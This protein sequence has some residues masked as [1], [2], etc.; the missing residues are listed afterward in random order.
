MA[1]RRFVSGLLAL[2]IIAIAPVQDAQSF[3]LGKEGA[4]FGRLG[5]PGKVSPSPI[6]S[7]GLVGWW[8]F[9]TATTSFS[10]NT[11][12]DL[13]TKRHNGTLANLSAP[14][15]LTFNGTT[16]QV[17]VAATADYALSSFSVSQWLNFSALGSWTTTFEHN[18][19]GLNWIFMGKSGNGNFGVWR[20]SQS[21][22]NDANTILAT[23]QDY[24]FTGTYDA[25]KAAA[26][27]YLNGLADVYFDATAPTPTSD[28]TSI[29]LNQSGAEGFT[30]TFPLK[31]GTK[32]YNRQ[33]T[34]TEAGALYKANSGV[35]PVDIVIDTDMTDIDD[36]GAIYLALA[37]E[38][39]GYVNIKA[40][41]T[42]S[43]DPK[44]APAVAAILRAQGRVG[45]TVGA[46]QGS[47]TPGAPASGFPAQLVTVFGANPSDTRANYTDALT[48]LQTVIPT[49]GSGSKYVSIGFLN[50]LSTLLQASGGSALVASKFSEIVVMGGDYVTGTGEFNFASDP[51]SAKY[52]FDNTPV[53]ITGIGLTIANAVAFQ[54]PTFA[55]SATDPLKNA[56]VKVGVANRPSWDLMAMHYACLGLKN[57]YVATG[58]NGTNTIN[59]VSGNNA[60]TSTTGKSSYL[61]KT[62]SDG[63]MAVIFNAIIASMTL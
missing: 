8:P 61:T 58:V 38:R 1:F 25:T 9:N 3:G 16:S 29:G 46:Y 51:V 37:A 30:G 27:F 22:S 49:M 21:T 54:P 47:A 63:T 20:V 14:V 59:N 55:S 52:V 2:L 60:W 19:S 23:G 10:N 6:V 17:T 36:V 57:Y 44:A 18:R 50:N 5:S 42:S 35:A 39:A 11:A 56:F 15:P 28:Q 33:L 34:S 43:S 41:V 13:S 48:V 62:P 7:S 40:I 53:G 12:T 4:I 31:G 32:L 24:N 26:I 45:V